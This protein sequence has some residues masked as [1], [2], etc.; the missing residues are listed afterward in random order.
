[1]GKIRINQMGYTS[2]R[3]KQLIYIGN[4]MTF[5]VMDALNH[6][7]VMLGKLTEQRFDEA[8]QDYVKTGDFSEV[9]DPGS[10]YIQIGEERSY[11]F[12]ISPRQ[13]V[14]CTDALLKGIYYQ[15]CG[16]E[17]KK[18]HADPW[19]HASCHLQPS[20]VFR[21]DA[22]LLLKLKPKEIEQIDTLGGWHDA[23]DYGRYTVGTI[24]TVADIMLAYEHYESVFDH[25]I[26]I[27]ESSLEG[28]DVLYEV[29]VG[30]DFLLKMQKISDG[31]V[32]TKVASRHFPGMIM[33]EKDTK[34]LFIFDTSSPATAGFAAVMAM[35][36]RI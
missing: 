9:I 19:Q 16:V 5:K 25:P 6:H 36:A 15:R 10:Y 8:S 32:Y 4:E 33:P 13:P 14:I 18:E 20:Y 17:L 7:V 26:D 30:L 35:A 1:M 21:Q 24:K 22:E 3:R 31:S 12:D 11:T 34:P 27:L 28:P 2:D 23:G 29:K